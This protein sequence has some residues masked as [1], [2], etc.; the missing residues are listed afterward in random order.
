[1]S[2]PSWPNPITLPEGIALSDVS[3]SEALTILAEK[4]LANLAIGVVVQR[5]DGAIISA[6]DAACA[7]LSLSQEQ[8]RGR[9]SF[10]PSWHAVDEDG[11][12]LPGERHPA[13]ETVE[14]AEAC[15]KVMGIYSGSPLLTWID[16]HASPI[17]DSEMNLV[18]VST[19]FVNISDLREALDREVATKKYYARLSEESSEVVLTVDANGKVLTASESSADLFGHPAESLLGMRLESVVPETAVVAVR[20]LI[21]NVSAAAGSSGRMIIQIELPQD[22]FRA[23]DLSIKNLMGDPLTPFLICTFRDVDQL[24]N[25]QVDLA[26][27]NAELTLTITQLQRSAAIDALLAEALEMLIRCQSL[28]EVGEVIWDCLYRVFVDSNLALYLVEPGGTELQLFRHVGAESD[29]VPILAGKCWAIRTRHVHLNA[30]HGVRCEH[31]IPE[32]CSVCL[33]FFFESRLVAWAQ[34]ERDGEDCELLAKAADEIF[35][36]LLHSIPEVTLSKILST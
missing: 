22:G 31:Q 4:I 6:N 1:M 11:E 29:N 14:T 26:E 5:P 35:R 8:L 13:M 18:G 25:L 3:G 36:R 34:I 33:P 21:N 15:H 16:V 28:T 19:S 27:A 20:T 7:I 23:Y 32:K 9:T 12:F 30:T 24:F 10:D 2:T 17:L